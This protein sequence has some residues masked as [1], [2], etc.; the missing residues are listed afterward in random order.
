[1]NEYELAVKKELIAELYKVA[2][3]KDFVLGVI[4]NATHVD[5]RKFLID[6]IH[7]GDNVSKKNL[8]LL[9]IA[10]DDLRNA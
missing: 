6:F 4:S 2:N 8:I 5:D 10:L 1:M 3:D 7:K 9:A